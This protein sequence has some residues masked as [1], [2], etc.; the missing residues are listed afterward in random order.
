MNQ[1]LFAFLIA[2]S[3]GLSAA[4]AQVLHQWSFNEADG[5]GIEATANSGTEA[6]SGTPTWTAP[7]NNNTGDWATTGS[8]IMRIT[9]NNTS[10]GTLSQSFVTLPDTDSGVVRFEW[11]IDWSLTAPATGGPRETFLI[12]R[13]EG[14]ANRFRWTLSNPTGGASPAM[15]LNID[16]N[17]FAAIPNLTFAN[18]ELVLD[19]NDGNLVLR[20]DFTFGDVGGT[21]GVAALEA[22]YSY[23]GSPFSVIDIGTFTPYAV[24]N[25]NDLRLHSKGALSETEFLDFDG[26]AVSIPDGALIPG[27]VNGDGEVGID[28]YFPI[29]NNFQQLVSNRIDGDLNADGLVNFIDFAEWQ[30]NA[31]ASVVAALNSNTIPEPTTIVLLTLGSLLICGHRQRRA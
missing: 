29:R 11:D 3:C 18:D 12:N 31:P 8:G 20:T 23:D 25:L 7:T 17:G 26:V 30:A 22:S 14:G 2:A 10:V 28:D 9:G 4:E 24:A 5:V 1:R 16:G 27:D 13:D 6:T 21:N 19:G 15:R